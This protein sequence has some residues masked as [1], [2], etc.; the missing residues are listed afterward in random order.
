L[1]HW[2]PDRG[3]LRSTNTVEKKLKTGNL[4][5]TEKGL[6]YSRRFVMRFALLPYQA[7]KVD[8]CFQQPA[9]LIAEKR[10]F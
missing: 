10:F 6:D 4:H 9:I 5:E 3:H 1:G 8:F 2:G 7:F